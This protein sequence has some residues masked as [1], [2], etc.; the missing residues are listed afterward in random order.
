[1]RSA[2]YHRWSLPVMMTQSLRA[3]LYWNIGIKIGSTLHVLKIRV[4]A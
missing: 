4:L 3:H 2:G 1:M